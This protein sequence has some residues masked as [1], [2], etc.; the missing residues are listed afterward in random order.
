MG[1]TR[2]KG[3]EI[4][5]Y[6]NPVLNA[7][8]RLGG[9]ARPGE[10]CSVVAKD[11]GLEGTPKLKELLKS[12]ASRF[13]NKVAWVRLYLALDGY[14][15]RSQ[16]GIWTLTEKGKSAPLFS[17]D[18]IHE[19]L[20][21]IQRQSKMAEDDESE[22]PEDDQLFSP[23]TG[24]RPSEAESSDTIALLSFEDFKR[25][26]LKDILTGDPSSLEKGRRFARKLVTQWKNIDPEEVADDLVFC[27]GSGDGGIDIAYLNRASVSGGST[28]EETLEQR[29]DG[30]TWFLVQ[31]KYGSAFRGEKTV[32]DEGRKIIEALAG[33]TGRLSSVA[34]AL[35]SRLRQFIA[36]AEKQRDS[37]LVV[38]ATEDG[39]TDAQQHALNQIRT[40]G[41]D[42]FGPLFDVDHVSLRTIY[43]RVQ[44]DSLPAVPEARLNA[45]LIEAGPHLLI[46]EVTLSE[47]F[48]FLESYRCSTGDLDQIYEK[49]V[50]KFL[51]A[52][53]KVNKGIRN[54]LEQTPDLFGL[55]NNGITIIVDDVNQ[56]EQSDEYLLIKPYI[57]NG[58]Q[59][60][61]CIWNV[62]HPR[63]K[64]GGTGTDASL[65]K[66]LVGAE[67]GHVV[68]KLVKV[69]GLDSAESTKITQ[70]TNT[71]NAVREKDFLALNH[72]FKAWA[73]QMKL[74][75]RIFLEIQRG[76]WDAWQAKKSQQVSPPTYHGHAYAFDLLK[77]YGAG[78]LAEVGSANGKNLEFSPNGRIFT[79]ILQPDP[80]NRPFGADDLLA[81][82][83][84]QSAALEAGFGRSAKKESRRLTRFLFFMV[85]V[86]LLKS[87]MRRVGMPTTPR[88]LTAA[89]LRLW[90]PATEATERFIENVCLCIDDYMTPSDDG[91]TIH[92]EPDFTGDL[93]KFLK[94]D[95]F[96]RDK[97]FCPRLYSLLKTY[98]HLMKR[99]HRGAS[100]DAVKIEEKLTP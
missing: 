92:H 46:G 99:K 76:D 10:V 97:S 100:S 11:L 96:G 81:A 17:D 6:V 63:L 35:L 98:E 68:L 71:Q 18:E 84:L 73:E 2:K 91:D 74:A 34:S 23:H 87:V 45:R 95:R 12:G 14:L 7:I 26:W 78:W 39:L 43:Q 13:E 9:S 20:L 22:D 67:Q 33:R 16:R 79:N 28:A 57:V 75:H 4:A 31:S 77:V 90:Q 70:N 55:Y 29:D 64:S 61:Q 3:Q 82:Y 66:W 30:D 69:R 88:E 83:C 51:G 32:F 54:T 24:A 5:K 44:E 72:E 21:R 41:V 65:T 62:F 60:T 1:K 94:S 50:R 59:T 80:A 56:I 19:M 47:I 37:L 58:C 8:K 42:E 27:D 48:A 40:L 86:E 36:K 53:G 49:N 85:A 38:L 15:D 52:K 25:S 93:N 89:F